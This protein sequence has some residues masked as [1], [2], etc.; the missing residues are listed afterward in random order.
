[1]SPNNIYF[2]CLLLYE[3]IVTNV[4]EQ[5]I[6]FTSQPIIHRVNTFSSFNFCHCNFNIFREFS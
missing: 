3:H 2:N 6:V 1:M 5:P 4:R